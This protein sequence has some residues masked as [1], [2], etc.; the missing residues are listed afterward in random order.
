MVDHATKPSGRSAIRLRR[1]G[2]VT[3]PMSALV[4]SQF[5]SYAPSRFGTQRTGNGARA[6]HSTMQRCPRQYPC[7]PAAERVT[8]YVAAL[9]TEPAITPLTAPNI[10]KTVNDA[11]A[12]VA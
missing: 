6:A 8:T 11:R 5:A 7:A 12:S 10:H 4:V 2:Y 9:P 1:A 3:K